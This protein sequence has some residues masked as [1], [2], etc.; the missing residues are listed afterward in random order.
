MATGRRGQ[1][2]VYWG[3][4]ILAALVLA[5]GMEM[6]QQSL[7]PPIY[8]NPEDVAPDAATYIHPGNGRLA[9]VEQW[10]A[11][12]LLVTFGIQMAV[13]VLLFPLKVG[14]MLV[15]AAKKTFKSVK[16]A[17][18]KDRK[19]SILRLL[20][21]VGT[22]LIGYFLI[23]QLAMDSLKKSN[24]MIDVFS[25]LAGLAA[26]M[27]VTFRKTL[28]QKPECFFLIL[29]LMIGGLLAFLLPD[30]TAVSWDDGHHYQHAL[31][32]STIGHVRFTQ[33]DMNAMEAHNVK[34]YSLGEERAAW[35][36]EQDAAYAD[37][38]VY[39]THGCHL[40]PTQFWTGFSGLGLFLGRLF[41]LNFWY[42]W[43]LG[44]FTGLLA[45]AMA[46]FFAIRRLHSGKMIVASAMMIPEGIFLASN[47]SYDP[48]VTAFLAL[49]L[50]YCF[51]QWQEP[52]KKITLWDEIIML[53]AFFLGCLAKAIYFPVLLFPLFFPKAK[54]ADGKHH[55]RFIVAVICTITAL[56]ASFVIAFLMGSG[57]G[58]TRGGSDVNAF[59]QVLFILSHPLEYTGVLLNFL[60][61]YLSPEKA[62]DFIG[63]FAYMGWAPN[64]LLYQLIL[65]VVVFTDK[66]EE[67]GQ[68]SQKTWLRVLMLLILFGTVCLVATSLYVS[69]TPVGSS[70]ISGCQ[71]RY[72]LPVIFPGMMLLGSGKIRNQMNKALYNGIVFT[73]LG[74]VGFCAALFT[75]IANYG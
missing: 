35:L 59:G 46:G 52:E 56:L 63:F 28:G 2:W 51:V 69:Y 43:S 39:V 41:H 29:T 26:A 58:D 57:E 4:M 5:A 31:N 20:L 61:S 11:L 30:A 3:V 19:D 72:L 32:Y 73:G 65:T 27:M 12:R 37:G 74:Y 55:K 17:I 71:P 45:Y 7:L 10:S 36:A 44:R 38:A 23:R 60:S 1:K 70:G 48:G 42:T 64:L 9:L 34:I 50:S 75:C 67:D 66:H 53:V 62:K 47:Y 8:V 13:L 40:R 15:D 22:L 18:L 21:F 68:L 14:R 49:G 6:L 25:A 33:Q 16:N 54:F 24:W